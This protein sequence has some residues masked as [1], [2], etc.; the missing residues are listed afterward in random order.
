MCTTRC[1]YFTHCDGPQECCGGGSKFYS[2]S[3]VGDIDV[4]R[5]VLERLR[6]KWRD[7]KGYR[8][9][10]M[11]KINV[12]FPSGYRTSNWIRSFDNKG[13]SMCDKDSHNNY[14]YMH[15]LWR[16]AGRAGLFL[17]E[18]ADCRADAVGST[19]S[20]ECHTANWWGML[21]FGISPGPKLRLYLFTEYH[22]GAIHM[23]S[24]T[25]GEG[26]RPKPDLS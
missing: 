1:V 5:E 24:L 19:A 12:G 10:I 18:H 22:F 8:N 9:F 6:S 16:S 14:L 25:V 11:G 2:L 15:G 21:I 17:L 13:W 4:A 3:V 23:V 26:D 20:Q 7:V